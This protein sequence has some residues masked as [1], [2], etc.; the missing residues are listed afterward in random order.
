[1]SDQAP[2]VASGGR[3]IKRKAKNDGNATGGEIPK[4]LDSSDTATSPDIMRTNE[5]PSSSDTRPD[6][7]TSPD[8]M[9]SSD[10]AT[11]SGPTPSPISSPD[12]TVQTDPTTDP[13]ILFLALEKD[14]PEKWKDFYARFHKLVEAVNARAPIGK[15]F[16]VEFALRFLSTNRPSAIL[17][18]D[19]AIITKT[20]NRALLFMVMSYVMNGGTAILCAD[21]AKGIAFPDL[22]PFFEDICGLPWRKGRY[23]RTEVHLN[24]LALQRF[25]KVDYL[26]LSDVYSLN[27]SSLK[28]VDDFSAWYL[29]SENSVVEPRPERIMPDIRKV[30][31]PLLLAVRGDGSLGLTP[32]PLAAMG[33]RPLGFLEGFD[34]F[35]VC[36]L[37]SKKPIVERKPKEHEKGEMGQTAVALAGK[38]DGWLGYVGDLDDTEGSRLV[39]LGMCGLLGRDMGF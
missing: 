35:S 4:Y 11:S 7:T 26:E 33:E 5:G 10:S 9:A 23:Y 12:I 1:M 20:A 22:D 34:P 32:V 24:R 25:S 39:I 37:P 29:P 14:N 28:N 21:F 27:A 16:D 18:T 36:P 17:I 2:A 15:A 8:P 6:P 19:P 3:T 38:G 13:L 30:P 31:V